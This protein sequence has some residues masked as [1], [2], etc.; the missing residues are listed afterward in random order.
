MRERRRGRRGVHVAQRRGRKNRPASAEK[1]RKKVALSPL[2]SRP[3]PICTAVVFWTR[4]LNLTKLRQNGRLPVYATRNFNSKP[5]RQGKFS[6]FSCHEEFVPPINRVCRSYSSRPRR[7]HYWLLRNLSCTKG[8][9]SGGTVSSGLRLPS[10][11]GALGL[12]MA[13]LGKR[14]L[15]KRFGKSSAVP[16]S[17][18]HVDWG[19][20]CLAR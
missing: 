16:R 6:E 17:A 1:R 5:G 4:V 7:T 14:K 13:T 20:S 18:G 9:R 15:G 3:T 11:C 2:K 12:A 8:A 19:V 10:S